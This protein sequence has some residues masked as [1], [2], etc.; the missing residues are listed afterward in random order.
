MTSISPI[1][2]QITP[3]HPGAHLFEISC[4]IDDPDP[5]GQT[6]SL[7]AW[8]PGS[9]MIREFA[10]NI[11]Q[12][13]ASSDD[14][15]LA[16]T[17]VDKSTWRCA[18][19]AAPLTLRYQVYAWDLSVRAAHLDNT[20]GFFNGTSVFVKIHGREHLPHT[21]DIRPPEGETDG[22]WRVATTLARE[23]AP[24]WGFGG[25]RVAD[26]DEL[27]DHPVE[28]GTF[29][30]ATFTACGIP[31]S[32]AITGRH[33]AD[34]ERLCRDLTLICE[35]QIRFFG[36]PAPM[37]RYLFLVTAVGN[38]YGGLEH[39]T[40]CA[41]LCARD[42]L[43]QLHQPAM[44]EKY[45]GFLTLCS[46]EYFHLWNVKR[47]KPA[48]FTPYAL[49]RESHTTLL[50]AFEGIT[51][52]YQSLMLLRCGLI[53]AADYLEQLGQTITRVW[54][55]AGRFKQSLAESSFDAWTKFYKQDENAVNAI[56]N[57]YAKGALVALALDLLI[58]RE[59]GNA[60]SL[61]DVMRALWQQ[62]GQAD[63]GVEEDD[64]EGMAAQISGLDLRGFFDA[65]VRGVEDP[66][67]SEL[68]H[69]FGVDFQLRPA[70]ADDDKGGR[71]AK[72]SPDMLAR[73][74][75]LGIRLAGSGT[76][77][78]VSQV[79]EGGAAQSAGLAVGDI[80][81]AVDH[82]RATRVNLDTLLAAYGPNDAITLH[83]FR[84]DEL[85]T[86]HV[87]LQSPPADTCVLT[88]RE[89][90]DDT[91]RALRAGWLQEA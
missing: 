73:R 19:C 80:I 82:L 15:P 91:T 81:M 47:I 36:E 34:T 27:I 8:I 2:F 26:Y 32:I 10:R 83:A 33:R 65:V 3:A 11:V 13:W 30:L 63:R 18:P 74:A 90:M 31:H 5:Q 77:A 7:P 69:R 68:F 76:D 12:L 6:F 35:Q 39:R 84:R 66:P 88:L 20:H 50:W 54:R 59:S 41:L 28:M 25:Y 38:G 86:F 9:Y 51:S 71:R 40:S 89:D 16:V 49:D 14:Q 56:V 70:E 43:P 67:L 52:Y 57:Y 48:V 42:D 75:V 64:V 62:Y 37:D 21:V 78:K 87:V 17:R 79:L 29:T 72:A 4:S 1:R 85:M 46:H 55:G 60:R 45:R 58:R 23:D 22:E 61:D 24:P 53:G 44:T